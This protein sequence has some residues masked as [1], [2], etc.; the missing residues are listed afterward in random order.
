L[1]TSFKSLPRVEARYYETADWDTARCQLC[2]QLCSIAPSRSGTCGVRTN[3]NGKLYC[4]NYGKVA[5][6]AVM[7]SSRLPLFH[8]QPRGGWLSVGMKGCNMRCPFCNTYQTSQVGGRQTQAM[9]PKDLISIA[10]QKQLF[11]ISFG[12]NEPL[13][14]HE[15]VMDV[16]Q[17]AREAGLATHLA[18]NGTY[19]EEPWDEVLSSTDAITIGFKGFDEQFLTSSCGGQI[20]LMRRNS[21]TALARRSHVELSYLVYDSSEK[22]ENEAVSF[23]QWLSQLDHEVPVII[24]SQEPSFAWQDRSVSRRE[25]L[26][27]VRRL[28][29]YL[30]FVYL[31]DFD[32]EFAHTHC[33]MCGQRL[34]TRTKEQTVLASYNSAHCPGCNA[35]VPYYFVD[36]T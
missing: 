31:Y 34:V 3:R 20:D 5:S 29:E 22:G 14:S 17:A 10:Q 25:V 15:F 9:R 13:V 33:D 12:V 30:K 18:T 23:A 4:D 6:L 28:R 7:E 8:Y 11:G 36:R 32:T 2:H 24:M 19:T 21:K 35:R 16:F 26:P 1:S 27:V